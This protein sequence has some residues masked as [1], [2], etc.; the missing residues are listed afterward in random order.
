MSTVKKVTESMSD[1]AILSATGHRLSHWL[2]VLD[3][4][5][6]ARNGHT[7][8]AQLLE[9]KHGQSFWWSQQIT[10]SYEQ[11]RGL[12]LPGQR[13]DGKFT[14][15]VAKTIEVSVEKAFE[16][17][18]TG[19]GWSAWFTKGAKLDFQK[20][21]SY[22]NEDKDVGVFTR[23]IEPGPKRSMDERARIEFTWEN[24]EHCPGSRVIVQFIEKSAEK[25]AVLI[26]H[27]RLPDAKGRDGMKEGWSWA[28]ASLK[29]YLET[30]A[31]I[32]FETW[33]KMQESRN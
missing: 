23:I 6:V 3:E 11:E 18:S 31:Q 9:D 2:K 20:G 10:I 4:F 30:G 7:A 15:N 21:G 14:V 24:A 25:C 27:E 8:A 28:L 29:S 32:P 1:E 16:A 5:D 26:S 12:R 22:E 19:S 17:W 33:K 13:A